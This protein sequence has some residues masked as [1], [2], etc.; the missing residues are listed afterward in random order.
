MYAG[1]VVEQATVER[2]FESP[3]HPYSQALQRSNPHDAPKGA[4]LP[5]IGGV[6][7]PAGRWPSG[8]HFAPRCALATDACLDGRIPMVVGQE[9]HSARCIRIDAA[10]VAHEESLEVAT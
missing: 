9:D 3:L 10:R 5:T 8:C 6:V 1:Q 7:P 4:P 2:V